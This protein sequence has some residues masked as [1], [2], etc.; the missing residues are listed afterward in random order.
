MDEKKSAP[1]VCDRNQDYLKEVNNMNKFKVVSILIY[2][3]K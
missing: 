3:L 2:F 1:K